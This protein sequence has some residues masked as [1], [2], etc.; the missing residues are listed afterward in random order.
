MWREAHPLMRVGSLVMAAAFCGS[1]AVA[2]LSFLGVI[3]DSVFLLFA[4]LLVVGFGILT[5][6]FVIDIS[7]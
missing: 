7:R 4:W 5:A 6:G 1:V 3:S 2:P